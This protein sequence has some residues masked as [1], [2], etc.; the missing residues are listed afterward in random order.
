MEYIVRTNHLNDAFDYNYRI[1]KEYNR[2][3]FRLF[4]G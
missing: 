1:K 4:V 2:F 3:L